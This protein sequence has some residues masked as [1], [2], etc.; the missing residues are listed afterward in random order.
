MVAEPNRDNFDPASKDASQLRP[1]PDSGPSH[2]TTATAN[3]RCP[4]R[5]YALRRLSFLTSIVYTLGLTRILGIAQNMPFD[6]RNKAAFAIK[7]YTFL[8][9]GFGLPFF[10]A[11]YQLYVVLPDG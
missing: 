5:E 10:A 6:Y 3:S 1:P 11:W 4:H 9:V 8:G 7:F 2:S